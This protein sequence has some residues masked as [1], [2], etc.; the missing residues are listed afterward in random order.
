[1]KILSHLPHNAP[2]MTRSHRPIIGSRD[3]RGSQGGYTVL[4]V[5]VLLII[6]A[7]L[8]IG[9]NIALRNLEQELH[10]IERQQ[11]QRHNTMNPT[12]TSVLQGSKTPRPQT[13]N[14]A[15]ALTRAP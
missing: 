1:M 4:V 12:N 8:A 3:S 5:L 11:Q 7:S 2:P 15:S 6:V 14:A 10:L 9:N 13:G